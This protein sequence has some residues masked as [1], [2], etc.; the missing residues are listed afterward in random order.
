MKMKNYTLL[1]FLFCFTHLY[2]QEKT[3]IDTTAIIFKANLFTVS[4]YGIASKEYILKD[5][6]EQNVKFLK[7]SFESFCFLKIQFSQPYR[8]SNNSELTLDRTCAYYIA[9]NITKKKFYRLGG[10][11]AVNVDDFIKDLE[12]QEGGNSFDLVNLNEIEEININCLYE[13]FYLSKKKK[14]KH[15]FTCFKC[16]AENTKTYYIEH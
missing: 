7:T 12:L 8:T 2:S 4:E 9:Y 13:Y 1:C 15:K 10:F 3:A 6:E 11:D 16:C 5:I 14:L